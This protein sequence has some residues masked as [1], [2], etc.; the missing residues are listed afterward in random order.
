MLEKMKRVEDKLVYRLEEISRIA[1]LSPDVITGWE[2]EFY[3]LHAGQ[4][5]SGHKIFRKKDLDIILRLKELL[6]NEG[7][8]LAGAKKRIEEEFGIKSSTPIHPDRLKKIL[9]KVREDLRNIVT[10]LEDN[11]KT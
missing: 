11:K 10:S 7:L 2:K 3:F 1:R 5:G 8:T 6:E 4:T 9:V